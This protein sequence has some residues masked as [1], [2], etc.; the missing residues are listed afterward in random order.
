M[1]HKGEERKEIMKN[2]NKMKIAAIVLAAAVVLG[3]GAFYWYQNYLVP[4]QEA[5]VRF[6]QAA[7]VVEN[8]NTKLED[9]IKAA[10]KLLDQKETPYDDNTRVNLQNAI[11]DAKTAMVTIPEIPSNTEQINQ[12]AKSLEQPVDYTKETEA[13]STAEKAY[14]DSIRQEKQITNPEETF[15]LDRL[16]QVD[17]IVNSAAVTEDNDPNGLLHK[18]GGYTS[19]VFFESRNVNQGDVYGSDLID[20]G[21]EAGGCI[22]VYE[23]AEDAK[24]RNAY[25]ASFDGS[26][27]LSSGSHEVLGT[28]VI[29]TSDKLTASQQKALT[30][31]IRQAFLKLEA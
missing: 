2:K 31:D 6:E 28:I 8:E 10:Q 18:A 23:S 27:F 13:L 11:N 14:T 16:K 5:T 20:K 1:L 22:E 29:R 17:T 19:A 26:G 21:T 3:A 7:E 12:E 9:S 25:L 30:E 15:V 24:K 4:K